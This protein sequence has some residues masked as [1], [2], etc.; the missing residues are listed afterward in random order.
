MLMYKEEIQLFYGMPKD[1]FLAPRGVFFFEEKLIVSDTGKNRILIWEKLPT[2]AYHPPDIV[3]GENL[4]YR[5]EVSFQYPSGIWTNGKM[6]IIA[7][8]WNHR[9]L[10]WKKFPTQNNEPATIVVGQQDFIHNHPNQLG[11]GTAPTASSLYWCYGVWSTGQD[12]WIADTGNRRILYFDHIPKNNGEM[13]NRVIGQVG[14][15]QREYNPQ[16]A[17]WPYS[18]KI[19]DN[20]GMIIADTQYY[21][22]LLWHD[23][24][25]SYLQPADVVIGQPDFESNGANQYKLSPDANT[26]NCCY[27][28]C[29]FDKQLLVADTGNSRILLWN[30]IPE[31]NNVL[32]NN[33]IGQKKFNTNGESSLSMTNSTLKNQMYWPFA[34]N[35]YKK[36]IAIADTGNN[37]ILLIKNINNK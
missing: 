25:T 10:I 35:S 7:D 21:R 12:L 3:L 17:I 18:I 6:L 30:S 15:E 31:K 2:S 34:V 4:K 33:L 19:A 29:F 13:A 5:T 28:A 22:C 24:R 26:L 16:N 11:V 9:V 1:E 32:A 37:R 36:N 27:D 14:F 23:F 20:G 8:A